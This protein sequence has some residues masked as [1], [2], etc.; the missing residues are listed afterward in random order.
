MV[1][2][3][4]LPLASRLTI[5]LAVLASV[6]ALAKASPVATSAAADP[7]T[8]ETTVAPCV[9]V[10]SPTRLPLK[11]PAVVAV[12]ALPDNAAVMVPAVKL[13]LASRLTIA[14]AVLASVA[15]FAN[16]SPVATFA[17]VDPPTTET[18]VAP[19]VPVTSPTRL[20]LKSVAVVAF[21]TV[22]ELVSIWSYHK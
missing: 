11:L 6:A 9:P 13:P 17:A 2:A 4:K 8:L 16:A 18:T 3:I 21:P 14:L 20:P 1:P 7:P 22:I 15:A 10:T 5:V 19:C 12:V